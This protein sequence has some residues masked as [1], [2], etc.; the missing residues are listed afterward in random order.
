MWGKT[1]NK[2]SVYYGVHIPSDVQL[3]EDEDGVSVFEVGILIKLSNNY[4]I[5]MTI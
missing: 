2:N 5:L 4:F 1:D 3:Q